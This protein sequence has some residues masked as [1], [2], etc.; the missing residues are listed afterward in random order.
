M[1]RS[2]RTL[3]FVGLALALI[4]AGPG[5]IARSMAGTTAANPRLVVFE[6][7]LSPT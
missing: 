6:T 1:A 5:M 3:L 7:F 4:L 2:W